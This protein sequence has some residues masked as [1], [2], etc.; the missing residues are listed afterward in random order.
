L[1]VV[2]HSHHYKPLNH[3]MARY[4]SHCCYKLLQFISKFTKGCISGRQFYSY[5]YTQ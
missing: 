2:A 1:Q 4:V 3:S 5:F